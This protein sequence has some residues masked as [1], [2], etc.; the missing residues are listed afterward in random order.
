MPE[1][2][3]TQ[4]IV[5]IAAAV[6]LVALVAIIILVYRLVIFPKKIRKQVSSLD[7]KHEYFTA[8]LS[9]QCTQNVKKIEKISN[10]NLL[11][12]EPSERLEKK[13]KEIKIKYVSASTNVLRELKDL[14]VE[15]KF[16]IA[17]QKLEE[18]RSIVETTE[19]EV[20]KFNEELNALIKPQEDAKALIANSRE[21]Y[22]RV[23]IRY[24]E[25]SQELSIANKSFDKVFQKMDDLF[26]RY[27]AAIDSVNT[28]ECEQL[29]P[30][31]EA[32][33]KELEKAVL[34][35]PEMCQA[36]N[37]EIPEKLKSL[38]LI[39]NEMIDDGYNLE[40][41]S[42]KTF[43]NQAENE[44]VKIK[45]EI[46]SF[47]LDGLQDR[48]KF[49]LDKIAFFLNAFDEEKTVKA[50]FEKDI[51]DVYEK[52]G[53][54]EKK[55]T[56]LNN[57]IP[58]INRI[59]IVGDEFM[60]KLKMLETNVSRVGSIKR[61][62]DTYIQPFSM[63]PFTVKAKKMEE[64]KQEQEKVSIE[65]DNLILDIDQ[66]KQEMQDAH[67]SISEY[68]KKAKRME[69][70]LD[71]INIQAFQERYKTGIA[72]I[73]DLVDNINSLLSVLPID[74]LN[75]EL[76]MDELKTLDDEVINKFEEEYQQY[77]LAEDAIVFTNR[78]RGHL[79]TVD[80]I[81]NQAELY[82]YQTAEFKK[83][84][85]TAVSAEKLVNETNKEGKKK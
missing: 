13:L 40:Q 63:Q 6:A 45:D 28:P 8:L 44:L 49:I 12:V 4:I 18:A 71:Q 30:T 84:Y 72:R 47:R 67:N 75:V 80:D 17:K 60:T 66:K 52:V 42:V 27:D 1:L 85:D 14:L 15:K 55:F 25:L 38:L 10:T 82:F 32:M 65:I 77:V 50:V 37:F 70:I 9:N 35:L 3:Q 69:T 2:S 23:K 48:I 41:L 21:R 31:L 68:F 56:K 83:A 54:L 19:I 53:V 22:R 59:Y 43:T 57:S 26:A 16:I 61:T 11:Y 81:L 79:S 33:S 78:Y 24:G 39:Y 20:N 51:G 46:R 36:V 58:E 5:I 62:L 76:N 29:A 74:I 64:L 7:R 73:Y 34:V